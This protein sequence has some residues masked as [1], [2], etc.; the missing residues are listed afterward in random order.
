MMIHGRDQLLRT[1]GL[2]AS[3][4]SPRLA[5]ISA[6]TFL[7]NELAKGVDHPTYEPFPF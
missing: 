2:E 1:R 5:R 3:E 4:P 6:S 7:R